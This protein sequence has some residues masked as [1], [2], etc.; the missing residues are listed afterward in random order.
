MY[1]LAFSTTRWMA[2]LPVI[3]WIFLLREE[4]VSVG[5]ELGGG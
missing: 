5:S 3:S 1:T 2:S 4:Y